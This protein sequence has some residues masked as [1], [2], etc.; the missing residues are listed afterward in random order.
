MTLRS[1]LA[2]LGFVG[3]CSFAFAGCGDDGGSSPA[4]AP[5]TTCTTPATQ[6]S[7]NHQHTITVT[8]ADVN[9]MANKTYDITGGAD[10]SHTVMVTA[11]QFGQIKNGQTL[12][13]TSTSSGHSHTVTI[14]CV[15]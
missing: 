15:S 3:A 7:D 13:I 12:N 9:A 11:A 14:M 2:C 5:A 6:I 4:D 8:L 10:H 1:C